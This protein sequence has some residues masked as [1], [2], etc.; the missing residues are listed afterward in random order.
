[1]DKTFRMAFLATTLTAALIA[2]LLFGTGAID[3]IS[4]TANGVYLGERQALSFNGV[5]PIEINGSAQG[6]TA[7]VS[8]S[9]PTCGSPG[10]TE[11]PSGGAAQDVLYWLDGPPGGQ[12]RSLPAD[13]HLS[14]GSY[15]HGALTLR[16]TDGNAV[17]VTGIP[18]PDGVTIGANFAAATGTL[19]LDRSGTLT[20]ITVSGFPSASGLGGVVT[21]LDYS[22]PTLTLAQS[23]GNDVT[24]GLPLWLTTVATDADFGGNG[25]SGS[26]ISLAPYAVES[27]NIGNSEI[28]TRTLSDNAV[29]PLKLDASYQIDRYAFQNRI[30]ALGADG[31]THRVDY[32]NDIT[33]AVSSSLKGGAVGFHRLTSL[34][35]LSTTP[36]VVARGDF[37]QAGVVRGLYR[38]NSDNR[39]FLEVSDDG[40][41][42]ESGMVFYVE[43]TQFPFADANRNCVQTATCE[44]D[45]ANSNASLIARDE[46]V[47][48]GVAL[49]GPV[50]TG[51]DAASWAEDG[52]TDVIPDDKYDIAFFDGFVD[53]RVEHLLG[54]VIADDGNL[55]FTVNAGGDVD[56]GGNTDAGTLIFR[57]G[58][59]TFTLRRLTYLADDSVVALKISPIPNAAQFAAMSKYRWRLDSGD[60]Y[61]FSSRFSESTISGIRE[62]RFHRKEE[63]QPTAGVH[64]LRVYS[65]YGDRTGT[66]GD[67]PSSPSDG[68][69]AR[70]D[71]SAWQ[72]VDE[73][74]IVQDS[75]IYVATKT[76]GVFA[77]SD[78]LDADDGATIACGTKIRTRSYTGGG[79]RAIGIAIPS[80]EDLYY[81]LNN[82]VIGTYT[83]QAGGTV[84][85]NSATFDVWSQ[86]PM[87]ANNIPMVIVV[88][89]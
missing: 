82:R 59:D 70:Y 41:Q 23:V 3:G 36:M 52:N 28:I 77:A 50:L 84:T 6:N 44:F 17:T 85:I 39:I 19:T 46:T 32:D 86:V 8:I 34:G 11:L 80:D 56:Y 30:E 7:T 45:W 12:W 29:T 53:D 75:R 27:G 78:F 37:L 14:Q 15:A 81:V 16:L 25:T 40:Y 71:G 74:C 20:D 5:Q 21:S 58:A 2:L 38:R 73:D 31:R 43:D 13:D 54:E 66:G 18:E 22:S 69:L 48:F 60:S 49:P 61:L 62:F 72:A 24:I 9:C 67:L 68:Q 65:P 79:Q 88:G 42:P 89:D 26:P 33:A 57:V 64:R 63:A 10:S 35:S 1:M 76:S 55:T 83:L 47:R 4:V 87:G 51:D